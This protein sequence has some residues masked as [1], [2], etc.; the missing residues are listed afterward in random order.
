M[1]SNSPPLEKFDYL[2]FAFQL[3]SFG[4]VGGGFLKNKMTYSLHSTDLE[5]LRGCQQQ[6]RLA[7]K[8]L[9]QRYFG[10]LM[11]VCMRYTG[12]RE[13]AM[14]V[15]NTAFLKILEQV[16]TYQPTGSFSGWMA[17][18]AFN[19]AIDQVRSRTTYKKIMDFNVEK[20]VSIENPA[21][22]NLATEELFELI[23]T[24]PTAT[25]TVFCLNILD[26]YAHKEIAALLN[27]S[28]GTSKWHVAE[29]RKILKHLI[30]QANLADVKGAEKRA[31]A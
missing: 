18:I 16:K 31:I 4:G 2:L 13:E 27:I 30:T 14:E 24:L 19:T 17:T 10:R 28:E 8:Y 1:R 15:L 21:L 26:G 5:L 12:N 20:D 29:A 22:D 11:S 7:Q 6:D 9:Y 25:R 23:Q 3:H